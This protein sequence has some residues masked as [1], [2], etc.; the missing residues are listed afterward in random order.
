M[1]PLSM[2]MQ[3]AKNDTI[4][5][6][7]NHKMGIAV[8]RLNLG[9]DHP[10]VASSLDDLARTYQ[11]LGD[12]E[13]ALDCLKEGLRIRR[14]QS[15]DSMEIA[16]NM[17]AM[18]IIFAATNNNEKAEECYNASYAISSRNGGDPKLEAQV[19]LSDCYL[20]ILFMSI[21]SRQSSSR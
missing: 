9:N 6:L 14:L 1:Y 16:T 11:K 21:S 3:D 19:N 13:T 5:A 20:F 12:N 7:K 18:G 4:E 10:D 17:F 2:L 8:R 15:N